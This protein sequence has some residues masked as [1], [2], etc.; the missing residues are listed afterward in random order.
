LGL[1][2]KEYFDRE[3][4]RERERERKREKE[5]EGERERERE[6]ER[7]VL[8]EDEPRGAVFRGASNTLATH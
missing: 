4:E 7:K 3:R 2:V 5:R 6:R 1:G 8:S